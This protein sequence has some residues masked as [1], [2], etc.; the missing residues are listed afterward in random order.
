MLCS[1]APFVGGT[2]FVQ[3]RQPWIRAPVEDIMR[4]F[5]AYVVRSKEQAQY[6]IIPEVTQYRGSLKGTENIDV[7]TS[8]IQHSD[9]AVLGNGLGTVSY[10][11]SNFSRNIPR[12]GNREMDQMIELGTGAGAQPAQ[13][14]VHLIRAATGRSLENMCAEYFYTYHQ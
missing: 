9:N 4:S 8:L 11:T 10:Y 6:T 5:G 1:N 3:A 12:T 7:D 14:P 13:Q 2:V